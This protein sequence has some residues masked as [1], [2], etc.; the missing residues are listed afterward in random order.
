MLSSEASAEP[1]RWR[2][3]RAEYL[4]AILDS[5][6][7]PAVETVVVMSSSQVGKT[8]VLNNVVGYYIDQDP[9]PI[10]VVYPTLEMATAWSKDRLAPMLRDSPCLRGKVGEPRART[11]E[12]RILHKVFPGGHVTA[13]GSNAPASLAARPIRIV[14]A[15]EVDRF[16]E[17]AGAEGDPILLVRKR[18]TTFWNRKLGLFSTPTVRGKSR[19]EAA[20]LE[21]DQRVYMVPCPACG[22]RFALRWAGV[23]WEAGRPET[24]LYEC[25]ACS[26]RY[27]DAPRH[28][29]VRFGTW[30]RRAPFVRTAGFALS[31]LVSPWVRLEEMVEGFLRA[32]PYRERLRAWI[33]TSLGETWEEDDAEIDADALLARRVDYRAEVP[34]PVV[35]LTGAVDVQDDRLEVEVV[36]W[37]EDLQSWGIRHA[38]FYG[39]PATAA[40]W[41]AARD[42]LLREW[43]HELGVPMR[44]A[45]ACVDTQGHHTL[46]AYRFCKANA[47]RRWYAIR[48]TS[49]VNAPPVGRPTK[50]NPSRVN[51]FTVN[52]DPFKEEFFARLSLA[53]LESQVGEEPGYPPGF[54]HFSTSYDD[55]FMLQLTAEARRTVKVRGYPRTQWVKVRPR[56]E[57]LDLRVYNLVSLAILRPDWRT[58]AARL[59]AKV[60]AMR[61]KTPSAEPEPADLEAESGATK[62][63]GATEQVRREKAVEQALRKSRPNRPRRGGSGFV[64]RW[65]RD[66]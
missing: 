42:L 43:Q 7:D 44:V 10:Q 62:S 51:L 65:R 57:G 2:T 30:H 40:P 41:N 49:G 47:A 14:L 4:R 37:A 50:S 61:T 39:D 9:A 12:N 11:G 3:D 18:A 22:G 66:P 6:S 60:A 32:K 25:E 34:A 19:I 53:P 36:G 20:Y 38:I 23:K 17:S 58:L 21:S 13:S 35:L 27:D 24:A 8:E 26:E 28:R 64:G 45:A 29:A 46:E 55:E 15:D 5:F 52:V 63:E 31:E 56:N 54:C 59:R 48:G 33:N 16:P 1:G